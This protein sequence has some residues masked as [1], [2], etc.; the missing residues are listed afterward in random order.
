MY[1]ICE[2]NSVE[3]QINLF[4]ISIEAL[5][6]IMRINSLFLMDV[7][8]VN[9]NRPS[10]LQTVDCKMIEGLY[11]MSSRLGLEMG[12]VYAVRL[13]MPTTR[14]MKANSDLR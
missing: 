6:K 13:N 12:R 5:Y 8:P 11:Y 7:C 14:I 4:I 10:L 9:G 2:S 1:C 3:L